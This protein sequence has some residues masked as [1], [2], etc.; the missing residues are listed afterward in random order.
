MLHFH[1]KIDQLRNLGKKKKLYCALITSWKY[2]ARGTIH[3]ERDIFLY[4]EF[5][6]NCSFSYY[7]TLS[8]PR[9]CY[10]FIPLCP[11]I[12]RGHPEPEWM[13]PSWHIFKQMIPWN[14]GILLQLGYWFVLLFHLSEALQG[15]PDLPFNPNSVN[16]SKMSSIFPW[17]PNWVKMNQ[18]GDIRSPKI[19]CN[20]IGRYKVIRKLAANYLAVTFH[21]LISI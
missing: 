21:L 20:K 8:T 2:Y 10:N 12:D 16:R 13:N 1:P 18:P 7:I 14:E 9:M 5:L 6:M 11:S 4:N 19:H 15:H 17:Y 3:T